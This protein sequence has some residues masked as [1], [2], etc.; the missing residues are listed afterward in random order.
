[1][2]L[3]LRYH[4]YDTHHIDEFYW[5]DIPYEYDVVGDTLI[6]NI[7]LNNSKLNIKMEAID[8]L[9]MCSCGKGGVCYDTKVTDTINSSL[10]MKC[11][12]TTN[13][14][15]VSG[16]DVVEKSERLTP[17]LYKD[18]KFIDS[19]GLVWY[20]TVINKPDQ[21]MIFLDG[22]N[23]EDAKWA[24]VPAVEIPE[25]ESSKYVN[26]KTGVSYKYRMDMTKVQYFPKDEFMAA[27]MVGGFMS[28]E[29]PNE[30]EK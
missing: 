5:N 18:M 10:C 20:P 13:T 19:N 29:M 3:Q 30:T 4:K 22:T 12:F 1:M 8:S 9:N 14:L 28:T 25:S 27:L 7:E 23:A 11:G 21:G 2:Y 17:E 6:I 26:P 16:S 15:L 24:F